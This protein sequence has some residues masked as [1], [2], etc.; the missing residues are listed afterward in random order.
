MTVLPALQRIRTTRGV[1]VDVRGSGDPV[2]LLHGIGG[3]AE[4]CGPLAEQLD[5]HRTLC[6]DAPGYGDSADPAEGAQVDHVAEAIALLEECVDAPAHLFGTSWGGVIA[7]QVALAR[8]DLVRSL[9]LADSTRGSAVTP[10][11]AASMRARV[12]DLARLGAR[13]FAAARAP[14]LVA[15][16]CKPDV[17]SAVEA[18]MARVRVPGYA[19]AAEHMAATDLGDVLAHLTTPTLVVVGADDV[20]TGVPES[21]LLSDRI[22]DARLEVIPGAGHAALQEKPQQI[23]D[24]LVAFWAGVPA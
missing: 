15:P 5:G 16:S 17:A 24:L 8:P 7:V 3:H 6:W 4:S 13:D 20:V 22:A 23:A 2:L 11:R 21:Q 18:G 10:E 19:A 12:D 1:S 14:R 9:V